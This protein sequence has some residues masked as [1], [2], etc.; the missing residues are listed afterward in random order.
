MDT[1]ALEKCLH[2]YH[3]NETDILNDSCNQPCYQESHKVSAVTESKWPVGS[4]KTQMKR[5]INASM[6]IWPDDDFVSSNFGRLM[7]GYDK[8]EVIHME[9]IP[10]STVFSLVSNSGGIFG[11]CLGASF[12]SLLELLVRSLSK[13]AKKFTKVSIDLPPV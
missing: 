10:K 13:L 6:G 11:I 1:A 12:I 3:D 7:I 9:E 4:E 8:F 2:D 5:V